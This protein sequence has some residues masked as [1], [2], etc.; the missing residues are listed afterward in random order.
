MA[1]EF[2]GQTQVIVKC[3]KGDSL[4]PHHDDLQGRGQVREQS[5]PVASLEVWLLTRDKQ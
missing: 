1:E 2:I 5:A 4:Q 3:Q